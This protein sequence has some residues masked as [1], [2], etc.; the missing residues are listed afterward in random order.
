MSRVFFERKTK[1]GDRVAKRRSEVPATELVRLAAPHAL[2][3]WEGAWFHRRVASRGLVPASC[4]TYCRTAFVGECPEGPLRLTLD[5]EIRGALCTDWALTA[6]DDGLPLLEGTV[7]LELKFRRALPLPFKDLVSE[8]RL[9][10]SVVSKYRLC[11]EA[12]GIPNAGR[13]VA[14]A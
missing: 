12:W 2:D 8:F 6:G 9:N 4:I 14:G 13:E 11:R 10:P 3:Q 5:R 7:I 1:A